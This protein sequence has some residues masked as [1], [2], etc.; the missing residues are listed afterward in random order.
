MFSGLLRPGQGFKKFEV[1]QVTSSRTPGGRPMPGQNEQYKGTLI[2]II[3]GASPEEIAQHKQQGHPITH[4]IV[5]RLT[6]DQ[7]R[8]EAT[9]VLKLKGPDDT[10]RKF[11]VKGKPTD[12]G[13]LG[14]F[15]VY[16]VEEREDLE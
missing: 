6:K 7:V 10:V 3:T 15:M 8:A 12:P 9:N 13:E 1:Y 16:K 2:G 4:T 5:Q 14:H 11:L